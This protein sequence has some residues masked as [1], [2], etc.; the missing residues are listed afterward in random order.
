MLLLEFNLSI[1][2]NK[3]REVG[4][5]AGEND[6]LKKTNLRYKISKLEKRYQ[7][8]IMYILENICNNNNR[9][10]RY[11]LINNTLDVHPKCPICG[12]DRSFNKSGFFHKTCGSK[13]CNFE[14]GN[15]TNIE[16]FGVKN[17]FSNK[18]IQ[19][20]IK[21]TNLARYGVE[22]PAKSENIQNKIEQTN[23][24]KYG[25]KYFIRSQTGQ[26][27]NKQTCL[28]NWGVECIFQSKEIQSNIRKTFL[29]KYGVEYLLRSEEFKN[30]YKQTCL[31]KYG[32]ELFVTSD[33]FNQYCQYF[34]NNIYFDSSYELVFYK[35]CIDHNISIIRE[36]INLEY[37]IDNEK[38]YY[39]PDFK[40]SYQDK[41]R[42]IEISSDYTWLTKSNEK[43]KLIHDNNILVLLDKDIQK[44]FNYCKK[45]NFNYK[46]CKRGE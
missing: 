41:T 25:N 26:E 32:S 39:Y 22:N 8:L 45:I 2:R 29:E 46:D 43:K 9:L 7:I 16:N 24:I 23:Q 31:D 17:V 1:L 30:K 18:D 35:Y 3:C 34:Y 19:E 28:R 11:C 10:L 33:Y 15:L 37:Y 12:R 5:L 21:Q 6:Q 44:Y 38:H 40:I 42:L 27:K 4:I 36:P 13:K 14:S 20:K